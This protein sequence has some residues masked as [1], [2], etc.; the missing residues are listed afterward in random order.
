MMISQRDIRECEYQANQ[1][2]ITAV[3]PLV[4][5]PAMDVLFSM[6]LQKIPNFVAF[7]FLVYLIIMGVIL[8]L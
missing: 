7:V 8:L 5:N 6:S 1:A 3:Y 4:F 2:T